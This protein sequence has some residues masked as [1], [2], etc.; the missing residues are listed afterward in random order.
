MDITHRIVLDLTQLN[1]L[2]K[3]TEK[4]TEILMNAFFQAL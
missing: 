2:R 4:V 1:I 3:Q